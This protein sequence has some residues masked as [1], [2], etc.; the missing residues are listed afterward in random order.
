MHLPGDTTMKE[1]EI[2]AFVMF[3][4]IYNPDEYVKKEGD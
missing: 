1:C 3:D 2:I 4:M